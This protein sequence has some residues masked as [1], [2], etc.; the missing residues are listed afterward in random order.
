MELLNSLKT[1]EIIY[2]I[3]MISFVTYFG[4]KGILQSL[5]FTIK[6]IGSITIPLI[7]YKKLHMLLSEYFID[8]EY[9]TNLLNHDLP[10][11]ILIFIIL[12]LISYSFFGILEKILNLNFTK[13][14]SLKIVDFFLG[15]L[16]GLFLFTIIFYFSYNAFLKNLMTENMNKVMNYNIEFYD[17]MI[18]STKDYEETKDKIINS[19]NENEIY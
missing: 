3:L 1:V 11:E 19:N 13:N 10:S 6:I 12:F 4:F 15:C 14:F 16:Y 5:G 17:K 2:F 18:S 9:L 7:F 8:N